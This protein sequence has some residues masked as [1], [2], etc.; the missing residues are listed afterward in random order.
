MPQ[1]S[2]RIQDKNNMETRSLSS[3]GRC[4]YPWESTLPI[5]SW[6]FLHIAPYKPYILGT[7]WNTWLGYSTCIAFLPFQRKEQHAKK[8]TVLEEHRDIG[9]ISFGNSGCQGDSFRSCRVQ[10]LIDAIHEFIL[11][12]NSIMISWK[13]MFFSGTNIIP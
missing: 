9:Q 7:W 3:K 13:L 11:I 10:Q 12:Q 1:R 6:I 2:R 4:G 8:N 5:V